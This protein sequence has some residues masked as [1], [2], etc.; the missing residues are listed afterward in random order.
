MKIFYVFLLLLVSGDILAQSTVLNLDGLGINI[1]Q[2][3]FHDSTSLE[4]TLKNNTRKSILFCGRK[5]FG[6]ARPHFDFSKNESNSLELRIGLNNRQ[7]GF[8]LEFMIELFEIKPNEEISFPVPAILNDDHAKLK[9]LFVD[10]VFKERT[11]MPS[12]SSAR[13]SMNGEAYTAVMS[14]YSIETN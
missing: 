12:N 4:V 11:D 9:K 10:F 13:F 3:S 6:Q 7:K 14:V 8:P 2:K 1:Q 5:S